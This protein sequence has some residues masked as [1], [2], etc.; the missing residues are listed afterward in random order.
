MTGG[1]GGGWCGPL[2][3]MTVTRVRP[4][5]RQPESRLTHVMVVV[6]TVAFTKRERGEVGCF[7]SLQTDHR[8]VFVTPRRQ[9]V[10]KII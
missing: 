4:G 1:G 5:A 8:A 9:V 2:R 6:T 10:C 3:S 7:M